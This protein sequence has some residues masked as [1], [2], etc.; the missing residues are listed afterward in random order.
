MA[1]VL[2]PSH[3][4]YR[5]T[6]N[7][8]K[9]IEPL[10]R[11]LR[12][13]NRPMTATNAG[14]SPSVGD[15]VKSAYADLSHKRN[16]SLVNDHFGGQVVSV[17]LRN[18]IS[19]SVSPPPTSSSRT[20]LPHPTQR[21]ESRPAVLE[22]DSLSPHV[23]RNYQAQSKSS[24]AS[25]AEFLKTTGPEDLDLRAPTYSP[26]MN[27]PLSPTRKKNFLLKFAVGKSA[28]TTT[29]RDEFPGISSG[30]RNLEINGP[31]S[32]P[33]L[34]QPQVTAAGRKYFAIKVDYPY[35]EKSISERPLLAVP[36]SDPR[37]DTRSEFDYHEITAR[38]KHNRLSSVLAS[39][40]SMEFLQEVHPGDISPRGIER[41]A[42]Y[43]SYPPPRNRYS[44]VRSN[45]LSEIN[46]PIDTFLDSGSILPGDSVSVRPVNYR[47][48]SNT[49]ETSPRYSAASGRP[50]HTSKSSFGTSIARTP[51]VATSVVTTAHDDQSLTASPTRAAHSPHNTLQLMASLE[52]L[53]DIRKQ[54]VSSDD[55]VSVVSQTTARSIQQRRKARREA[56]ITSSDDLKRPSKSDLN[57]K[58]LPLLP[59]HQNGTD[60]ISK[61][62]AAAAAARLSARASR[63]SQEPIPEAEH[64]PAIIS[65]TVPTTVPSTR[66]RRGSLEENAIPEDDALSLRSGASGYRSQRRE[67]V[68]SKRQKDMDK[69]REKKLDEAM[70][71]LQEDV[72]RK[73]AALEMEEQ[74]SEMRSTGSETPR[75]MPSLERL[76][77][78]PITPPPVETYKQFSISPMQVVMDWAPNGTRRRRSKSSTRSGSKRSSN[79]SR[80]SHS[81]RTT[82]TNEVRPMT[83]VSSEP[84]TP[85]REE[86]E[87]VANQP[88]PK[89]VSLPPSYPPPNPSPQSSRPTSK[90]PTSSDDE[91]REA[92]IAALEE[93]KWVLEQ[94]LRVL[95]N[96]QGISTPVTSPKMGQGQDRSST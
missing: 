91:D 21:L 57:A 58:G 61:A 38:K 49:G 10:H 53:D 87:A 79:N 63:K 54:K 93:Q 81:S 22:G 37:S 76:R 68:R 88:I 82:Y 24:T 64:Q 31:V 16:P 95:L 2:S 46:S 40:A 74:T 47:A 50:G 45:S 51:S 72:Q 35:D 89:M 8:N 17:D 20:R 62:R 78:P 56:R 29:R 71:L 66:N 84:S 26:N 39:D 5:P 33:P 3:S 7:G 85:T 18:P 15:I 80:A 34:A 59:P 25:L 13:L 94:A 30:M 42:S 48:R 55:S 9:T 11:D 23:Y 96:Q 27:R 65:T 60:S 36:T 69:E 73:K 86:Y 12:T 4:S 44:L 41:Y 19:S 77:T 52:M 28:N 43:T 92:R 70:R 75:Q 90:S 1:A 83:P 6:S 14:A 67:R 32:P